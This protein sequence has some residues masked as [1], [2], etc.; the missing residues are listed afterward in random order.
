VFLWDFR[1]FLELTR[2]DVRGLGLEEFDCPFNERRTTCT[3]QHSST[4]ARQRDVEGE[5][6]IESIP[7]K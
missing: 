4:S 3:S 5:K 7:I 6:E 1:K 2:I